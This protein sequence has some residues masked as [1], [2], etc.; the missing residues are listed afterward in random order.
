VTT[1]RASRLARIHFLT[2]RLSLLICAGAVA[3]TGI[4]SASAGPGGLGDVILST[5]GYSQSVPIEVPP[6]HGLEPKLSLS[7]SSQGGNGFVGVGWSLG[8]FS[9]IEARRGVSGGV[10]SYSLDGQELWPC[11]VGSV[12]PSCTTGGTHSTK[13]ESYLKIKFDS[14][15]NT[16][17]VWGK[18]GT[19]TILSPTL[20]SGSF[21]VRWG[22]TS[23]VDTYGNTVTYTWA[24]QGGDYYPSTVAYNGYVININRESRPDVLSF[25]GGATLWKT[26]YRLRSVIVQLGVT[27]IRGYNLTYT[28][29]ALTG[30]SLVASIQQYGKDLTLTGAAITGGTALPAQTFTYQGDAI[31]QSFPSGAAEPATPS[32][33]VEPVTWA[34]RVRVY[35][36]GTGNS[37]LKESGSGFDGGASSTRAI[38]SGDGYVQFTAHYG[39]NMVGLSHGDSDPS[40]QDIDFALYQNGDYLYVFQNGSYI[41][42]GWDVVEGDTLRVEVTGGTVK[43]RRNGTLLYTSIPSPVYPLLVDTSIGN[44]GSQINNVFISGSLIDVSNWCGTNPLLTGDF[45]GDGRTDQLCRSTPGPDGT[46]MSL[47][48]RLGTATGFAAPTVWYNGATVSPFL[49]DFNG[50]GKT[51]LA[52]FNTDSSGE[53]YVWLS[54]GSSFAGPTPWG[55]TG[56]VYDE[57]GHAAAC[58]GVE[59][60]VGVGDFNGDGKADVFCKRDASLDKNVFV[61]I[62]NGA[63]SFSFSI[64]L[65]TLCD[66]PLGTGDFN[67]DAKSDL[68]CVT[69]NTSTFMTFLSTGGSFVGGYY[70]GGCASSDYLAVDL[71]GDGRSDVACKGNGSVALSNGVTFDLQGPFGGWCP[72]GEI[73]VGDVDGDGVADLVCD[74]TSGNVTVRR[75]QGSSLGAE[76]TW[77][78]GWCTSGVQ[79]GDFNGDGKTDLF[80]PWYANPVAYAG[81]AGVRADLVTLAA[82]G[83]G[84]TSQVS[85]VPMTNFVNTNN[86]GSSPVVSSVTIGDGRGGSSTTTYTYAGGLINRAEHRPLG[87]ASATAT[88]PCV[89]GE[90]TCPSTET[91]FMQDL[92]SAGKLSVVVQRDQL[93][94]AL[95]QK[96]LTYTTN[97]TSV[98]RTSLLTGEWT[99]TFDGSGATCPTYPCTFG[100]RTLQSYQYDGYGNP[101]RKDFSGDDDATGDETIVTWSYRPNTTAYIVDRVAEQKNFGTTLAALAKSQAFWYDGQNGTD[102]PPIKGSVT[103]SLDWL[104][105]GS[106]WVM[107]SMAYDSFGNLTTTT[108][109]TARAITTMFDSTYHVFPISVTNGA[110]ESEL[111]SWDPVCGLPSQRTDVAGQIATLQSDALCRPTTTAGPLAAFTTRSYLQFGTV[112]SQRV[113]VESP[114][115]TPEDGTGNDYTLEY[116]DGLARTYRVVKKGP[117]PTQDITIDTTFDARGQV[118]SR[119]APYYPADAIQTTSFT[120]D[121]LRRLRATTYPDN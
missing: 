65:N 38:V 110:S 75:W 2:P 53:F 91:S 48:V 39:T 22:Q 24:S 1:L 95:T 66:G 77:K 114:S 93:G 7:Y 36:V 69:T 102:L 79:S 92:G 83:L 28:T 76:Q 90:S 16:W 34:N 55:H 30:R 98:P 105:T 111:T 97:G 42:G 74:S 13:I 37:L 87:F 40:Y 49:G 9:V 31:G 104:N 89:A 5:G 88:L 103:K 54:T 96:T 72:S 106:R 58:G 15:T 118:A 32:N 71:N 107:T 47:R 113:R 41:T 6:F 4:S 59:T 63:S 119:T 57:S 73:V 10:D 109:P 27:P 81:S 78:T 85:H 108:D 50:D 35:A 84:G 62:S 51:D 99:Y 21:T 82:N 11:Q 3:I 20:I 67:G 64:W 60:T 12:S 45:N 116:F 70:T 117:S 115:A 121:A 33:T 120:Y 86:P 43:Y 44:V 101:I 94:H 29:S 8:G 18:D 61:G 17:T 56:Q 100:K 68:S 26:L 14:P 112:A 23:T 80:C 25:A 46:G 52:Y 19:K